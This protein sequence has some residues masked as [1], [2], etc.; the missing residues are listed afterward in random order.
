MP[1]WKLHSGGRENKKEVKKKV[2]KRKE[3][4]GGKTNFIQRRL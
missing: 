1:T 4:L 3:R 2:K